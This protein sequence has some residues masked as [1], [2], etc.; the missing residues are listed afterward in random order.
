MLSL[1]RQLQAG[2]A[3]TSNLSLTTNTHEYSSLATPRY[4]YSS[5]IYPS[6]S[7]S[8][9]SSSSS[10][11]IGSTS[12]SLGSYS[13]G[14]FKLSKS[15]TSHS[16]NGSYGY[17]LPTTTGTGGLNYGYKYQSEVSTSLSF[18]D[19]NKPV[20][21]DTRVKDDTK[22]VTL[23]AKEATPVL[24][25]LVDITPPQTLHKTVISQGI[26]MILLL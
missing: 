24:P 11:G 10:Y 7:S 14:D 15:V 26:I 23:A 8:L 25:A 13:V 5:S 2:G 21:M 6:S 22:H 20:T 1:K 18:S 17:K 16:T 3:N 4:G 12:T 19:S 9:Y